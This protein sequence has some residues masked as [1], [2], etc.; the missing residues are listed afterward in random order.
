MFRHLYSNIIQIAW[1]LGLSE[2][3]ENFSRISESPIP[4]DKIFS[5]IYRSLTYSQTIPKIVVQVQSTKAGATIPVIHIYNI[6]MFRFTCLNSVSVCWVAE[7]NGIPQEQVAILTPR[8]HQRPQR[9]S[10]APCW[11]FYALG[12]TARKEIWYILPGVKKKKK[13]THTRSERRRNSHLLFLKQ[14]ML[15]GCTIKLW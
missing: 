8:D 7:V 5:A 4:R 3:C 12:W 14:K 6:Y 13:H 1:K 2:N 11:A 10:S 15:T 9:N